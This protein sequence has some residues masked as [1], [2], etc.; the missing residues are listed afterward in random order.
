MFAGANHLV[1]G[2]AKELRKNMTDAEKFLCQ[3]LKG[4]IRGL[5]FRRQHPLGLYVA[6]FYC[7]KIKLVIELDGSIHNLETIKEYDEA[8]QKDLESEGFHFV[9]FSN[10][11]VMKEIE[12]VLKIIEEQIENLLSNLIYNET[13]SPFRGFGGLLWTDE[14]H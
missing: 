1:F 6:N 14:N 5:K 9:R 4:G 7:H 2:Y 11:Q 3:F 8:R 10:N 12:N 13:K